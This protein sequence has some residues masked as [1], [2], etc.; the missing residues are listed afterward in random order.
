MING[1]GQCQQRRLWEKL[2]QACLIYSIRRALCIPSHC[3]LLPLSFTPLLMWNRL[4]GIE[5]TLICV[6]LRVEVLYV[7]PKKS[8]WFS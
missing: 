5:L 4:G 3:A 8:L 1:D 2:I 6:W 7:D